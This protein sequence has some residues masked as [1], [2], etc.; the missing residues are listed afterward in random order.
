[1][2]R[3][4]HQLR[5][6][7]WDQLNLEASKQHVLVRSVLTGASWVFEC[8]SS[9]KREW[10]SARKQALPIPTISFGN[11][12]WGGTGKTPCLHHVARF[13]HA[14][15]FNLMLVSR[16]YGDDEW[17]MFEAEF[18][19]SLLAIGKHRYANAMACL[20]AE[21]KA[22]TIAL[23]DDGLQQWRL[24]KDLEIVMVDAYNP[25]GNGHLI[26][27]G[28]LRE[29]PN[30]ALP[31]ADVIVLHHARHLTPA[32]R[33]QLVSTVQSMA[34]SGAIVAQTHVRLTDLPLARDV[35]SVLHNR[36]HNL[37][38]PATS[39]WPVEDDVAVIGVCG[40]GCPESFQDML[41]HSFPRQC[42][43]MHVFPDHHAFT[44]ADMT[45]IAES[46]ARLRQ[47]HA[48]VMV[49]TTEKDF[50]RSPDLLQAHI[51][52]LR[53]ALCNMEFL[54][55]EAALAARLDQLVRD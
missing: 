42:V 48:N 41:Q 26:P 4:K 17:K 34:K 44:G 22:Q 15:G 33:M 5:Q 36:K 14:R 43:H 49:V 50:F 55:G 16:G 6:V 24:K 13:L 51:K 32:K 11:V 12:T 37:V 40:I 27:K 47:A 29:Y 2:E 10:Q 46:V 9:Q 18:P 53:V 8:I 21:N 31:S 39:Y 28:R 19:G 35:T 7:V 30:Q 1:M 38:N 20:T 45:A 54:D 52:D 23:V 3:L 25:F